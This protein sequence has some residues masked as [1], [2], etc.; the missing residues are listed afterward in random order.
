MY[1]CV[2]RRLAPPVWRGHVHPAF[3][4]ERDVPRH[5]HRALSL[6]HVDGICVGV[7]DAERRSVTP[8]VN[9]SRRL[10]TTSCAT[11]PTRRC[12]WCTSRLSWADTTPSA[13]RVRS[14]GGRSGRRVVIVVASPGDLLRDDDF[15]RVTATCWSDPGAIDARNLDAHLAAYPY[16]YVL[17]EPKLCRTLKVTCPRGASFVGS[18]SGALPSS[19]ISA[20][21]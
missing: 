21:G 1:F 19:I 4:R 8:P 13:L 14:H 6:A 18:L 15:N 16:D 9:A 17:Y 20:G 11:V 3:R 2:H 10:W 7:V 12:R 5:I